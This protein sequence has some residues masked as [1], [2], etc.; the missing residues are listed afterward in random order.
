MVKGLNQKIRRVIMFLGNPSFKEERGD[1]VTIIKFNESIEV[2]DK[3]YEKLYEFLLKEGFHAINGFENQINDYIAYKSWVGG[4]EF[5]DDD[6]V[7]LMIYYTR[8]SANGKTSYF[9]KKIEVEE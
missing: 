2:D 8:V 4:D 3:K 9:I 7:R 1:C 5:E 6:G